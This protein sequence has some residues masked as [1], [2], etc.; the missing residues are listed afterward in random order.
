[1]SETFRSW[2]DEPSPFFDKKSPLHQPTNSDVLLLAFY[3]MVDQQKSLSSV[4]K[5]EL[6][7][8]ENVVSL[9][10]LSNFSNNNRSREIVFYP[11]SC[12]FDGD[13]VNKNFT[14]RFPLIN[15]WQQFNENFQGIVQLLRELEK[16]KDS[17]PYKGK[18]IP[19]S[20]LFEDISKLYVKHPDNTKEKYEKGTPSH[21]NIHYFDVLQSHV[22]GFFIAFEESNKNH[23]LQAQRTYVELIE[24][25]LDENPK[26]K[27]LIFIKECLLPLLRQF[28][29]DWEITMEQNP[30]QKIPF[31]QRKIPISTSNKLQ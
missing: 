27:K 23:Q 28:H 7:N 3:L 13:I 31:F 18:K 29:K 21:L 24:I 11:I 25:F 22:K 4:M 6:M 30:S 26:F 15:D 8:F 14:L 20:K 10:S 17:T 19:F 9:R 12:I 2:L 16:V 1:M 5:S